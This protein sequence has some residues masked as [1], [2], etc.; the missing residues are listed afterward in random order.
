[1]ESPLVNRRKLLPSVAAIHRSATG[2]SPS[3]EFQPSPNTTRDPSGDI[4]TPDGA[5][6]VIASCTLIICCFPLNLAS[7]HWQIHWAQYHMVSC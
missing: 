3:F 2:S 4:A 6:P 7:T 1:L 5:R